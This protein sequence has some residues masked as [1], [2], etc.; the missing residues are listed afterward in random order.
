MDYYII[1][2]FTTER[3]SGNPA[4]VCPLTEWLPDSTLLKIAAQH[5]LSETAFFI[6]EQNTFHLRWFTPTIEVQLCGHATLAAAHVIFHELNYPGEEIIFTSLSGELQVTRNDSIYTLNFPVDTL[7]ETNYPDVLIKA[8]PKT[9]QNWGIGKTFF[10]VEL[11]DED[12]VHALIPDI[13]LLKQVK[14]AGV[15]ITA[16]G[17]DVDFVSRVFA[18]QSGIDEDPVTGSAHCLLI[19][20]WAKKLEKQQLVARQISKR[21]GLLYCSNLGDRVLIGGKAQTFALGKMLI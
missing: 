11:K 7:H 16:K 20:Y 5:N 2:A 8:I 3:F 21:G 4:A 19:P 14:A 15:I 1:N 10:L 17:T 13:S 18:P 9:A 12:E 6:K